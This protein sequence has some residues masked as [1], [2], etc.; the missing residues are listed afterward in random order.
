MT[1]KLEKK[2]SN[3]DTVRQTLTKEMILELEETFGMLAEPGGR[4]S[5]QKLPLALRSLG[6]ST[7]ETNE[8]ILAD[9]ITIEKFLQI[10]VDC[11][12][13]PN[14]AA[15]EMNES[16]A[17]FDKEGDGVIQP[18]ALRRVFN[19]LGEKLTDTELEDS[20][21]EYDIDGDHQVSHNLTGCGRRAT[22]A[23]RILFY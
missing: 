10:V 14:W 5:N 2:K 13:H 12:K 11:M 7:N 19:K 23:P 21:K 1:S 3:I 4:M 22:S 18:S 16:F 8:S 15:N 9:D 6:M 17:L 20:L